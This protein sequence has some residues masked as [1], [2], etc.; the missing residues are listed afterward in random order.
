[1]VLSHLG[2]TIEEMAQLN[3]LDANTIFT[4]AKQ[5]VFSPS[6]RSTLLFLLTSDSKLLVLKSLHDFQT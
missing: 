4:Y 3:V 5:M 1:M 6:A 2:C